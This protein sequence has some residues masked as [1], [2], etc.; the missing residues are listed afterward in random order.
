[1]KS[2]G[3]SYFGNRCVKNRIPLTVLQWGALCGAFGVVLLAYSLGWAIHQLPW[4]LGSEQEIRF[5][6]VPNGYSLD[7][8]YSARLRR[9]TAEA[10][11]TW[12]STQGA[13]NLPAHLHDRLTSAKEKTDREFSCLR[14]AS[15]GPSDAAI[16][17]FLLFA[18]AIILLIVRLVRQ[19]AGNRDGDSPE[20]AAGKKQPRSKPFL[21]G[22][23]VGGLVTLGAIVIVRAEFG[24]WS[25]VLRID[26]TDR[27][28]AESKWLGRPDH[29][30][31]ERYS[32]FA[33]MND[34]TGLRASLDVLLHPGDPKAP[35]PPLRF[36]ASGKPIFATGDETSWYERRR[37]WCM[38]GGI[39][40]GVFAGRWRF[41]S[42][43][44]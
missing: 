33:G 30:P 23:L 18:P 35:V 5:T 25:G 6:G 24:K 41:G 29:I 15:W 9:N 28:W 22:A 7:D 44:I 43:K 38:I 16:D 2:T 20:E 42:V 21:R 39:L 27:A 11:H 12:D 32:R 10:M 17:C 19:K 26:P 14:N 40:L 13:A 34:R 4:R 36:D 1:M 3:T 31:E 8:F 37:S